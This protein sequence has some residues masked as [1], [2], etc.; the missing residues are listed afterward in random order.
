VQRSITELIAILKHDRKNIATFVYVSI[1]FLNNNLRYTH[2]R[3]R[4]RERERNYKEINFC[5]N[6]NKN[7]EI[8]D[9]KDNI[10]KLQSNRP[11]DIQSSL[12]QLI[13]MFR[14]APLLRATPIWYFNIQCKRNFFFYVVD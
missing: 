3:E 13:T 12:Y 8:L 11:S 9:R 14:I 5:T 7:D 6:E 10:F 4:E 2:A 1:H